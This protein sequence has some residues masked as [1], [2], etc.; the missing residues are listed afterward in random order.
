MERKFMI[1]TKI[2]N[3]PTVRLM[4]IERKFGLSSLLFAKL[5]GQNPSGSVKDR[6][7]LRMINDAIKDGLLSRGGVVVEA[8]SGNLGVS[9]AFLS[10]V[11]GFDAKIVM[12]LGLSDERKKLIL[13]YGGDIIEV[14][15]GM[16]VA[17]EVAK[18]LTEETKNSYTPSQFTN[19]SNLKSH[20]FTTGPE[21]LCDMGGGVDAFIC[22]VGSGGTISGAG[23]YL[24]MKNPKIKII[25]V[26]PKR[27]PMLSEGRVGSHRIQGIGADF[28]PPLYDKGLVDEIVCIEDEEAYR[29]T[30]TL[31]MEEGILAGLSSGATLA[32]AV[33]I[34]GREDMVK[35]KLLA[36][37]PDKGERYFST[38]V[39]D[40]QM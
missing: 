9:L 22:G 33:K 37:F 21:I 20:F 7:A 34:A 2:G 3:T 17:T 40:L 26:E 4:K 6:A 32:A 31:A 36:I 11:F 13:A 19:Q 38:G 14:E 5:E 15:G 28:L 30:K 24:K 10:G 39:F 29:F 1:D 35:R 27:S 12:P 18:K 8:T 25:A 16:K 23:R